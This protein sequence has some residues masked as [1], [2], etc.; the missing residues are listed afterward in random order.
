MNS[1]SAMQRAIDFEI[2]RQTALEREGRGDEIVQETRS[3]D[4]AGQV[5]GGG[6][7]EI[8]SVYRVFFIVVVSNFVSA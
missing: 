4:E 1:F 6:G 2:G 7:T 8:D 3:W 5:R